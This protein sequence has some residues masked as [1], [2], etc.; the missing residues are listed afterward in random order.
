MT[1]YEFDWDESKAADNL[2]KHGVDF[3]TAMT[4]F[5][6]PLVLTIADPDHSET[7]ERWVSLGQA[8]DRR[9]ILTVHTFTEPD[10]EKA[11]LRIISARR[12]TRREAR[13]YREGA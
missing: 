13:Q 10:N 8:H 4:I 5:S 1:I 9:L 12:P 7:E 3:E 6:D 2:R 11:A